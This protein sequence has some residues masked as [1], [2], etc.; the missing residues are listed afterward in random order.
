MRKFIKRFKENIDDVPTELIIFGAMILLV[1]IIAIMTVKVEV[2]EATEEP[3]ENMQTPLHV[4]S[5]VHNFGAL[6]DEIY[7]PLPPPPPPEPPWRPPPEE[8]E[9]IPVPNYEVRHLRLQQ[10][11]FR[12]AIIRELL[13]SPE[14]QPLQPP[15][16]ELYA[17]FKKTYSPINGEQN[18]IDD[19]EYTMLIENI[20]SFQEFIL[21][22]VA[23][24]RIQNVTANEPLLA[25]SLWQTGL[26]A[27]QIGLIIM[28]I[29]AILWSKNT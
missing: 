18:A 16:D 20:I 25:S 27:V 29:F 6:A 23:N 7:L 10:V 21:L 8:I 26:A 28:V 9:L 15:Y 12:D 17:M 1:L 2:A 11:I 4:F 22:T 3:T 14:L 5:D 13:Q 19:P 24:K